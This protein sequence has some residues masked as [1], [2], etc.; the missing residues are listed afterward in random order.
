MSITFKASDTKY[1]TVNPYVEDPSYEEKVA[2]PGFIVLN[3][4]NVNA[5]DLLYLLNRPKDADRLYGDWQGETLLVLQ[6]R[7][8]RLRN[9]E[10]AFEKPTLKTPERLTEVGRGK[11]YINNRLDSLYELIK[12]AIERNVRVDFS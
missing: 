7:L 12:G 4:S 10:G 1:V 11:S 5:K 3:M 2:A 9:I 8:L 6:Q